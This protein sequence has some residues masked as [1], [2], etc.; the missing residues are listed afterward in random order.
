MSE[1][2]YVTNRLRPGKIK[3]V[4]ELETSH[5]GTKPTLS[6]TTGH[7]LSPYENQQTRE[8]VTELRSRVKVEVGY[9][10]S[11]PLTVLISSLT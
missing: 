9:P 5:V 1:A 4:E 11:P 3:S 7:Q 6:N 10:G 8:F 2:R